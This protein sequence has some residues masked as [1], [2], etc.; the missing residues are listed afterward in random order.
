LDTN[1]G[2]F[3]SEEPGALGLEEIFSSRD[4]LDFF[5]NYFLGA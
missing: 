3:L 4:T 1:P 2:L 5:L